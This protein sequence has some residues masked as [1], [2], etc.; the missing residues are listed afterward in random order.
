MTGGALFVGFPHQLLHIW[1][2]LLTDMH[3][4][5]ADIV[6]LFPITPDFIIGTAA[7][8]RPPTVPI[9]A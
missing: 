6:D 8:A 7:H 4:F 3:V 5:L 9:G 2:D 1:P